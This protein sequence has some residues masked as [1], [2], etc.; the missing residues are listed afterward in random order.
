MRRNARIRTWYVL[1]AVAAA[2]ALPLALAAP[3]SAGGGCHEAITDAT[4]TR[5]DLTQLCFAPTVIRVASGG[6]VTWT[7]RD[8]TT[9]T[10]T[11]VGGAWGGYDEL[12][13]GETVAFRFDR[14]GVFPY[15]CVIHPGMVGA[16]VV[17]NGRSANT[18][19]QAAVAAVPP[20]AAP[21]SAAALPTPAASE[22]S[23][24]T[25][26]WW[27]VTA[28]AAIALVVAGTLIAVRR[29]VAGARPAREHPAA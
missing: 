11:G 14:S 5:V 10:V 26:G 18:T 27:R 6:T 29:H 2:A 4:G 24:S 19:S 20:T 15:F 7:N 3:A 25:A 28:L 13:T 21:P 17:G 12:T 1:T 22:A 8:D 16:V 9:H 23:G